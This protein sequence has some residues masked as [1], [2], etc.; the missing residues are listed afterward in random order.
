MC[1]FKKLILPIVVGFMCMSFSLQAQDILCD[2]SFV[3]LAGQ[4]IPVGTVNLIFDNG[5]L[6]VVIDIT[7]P[8]W[9]L[10]ITHVDAGD[11]RNTF[12]VNQNDLP[13]VGKF[14]ST[15][16]GNKIETM[17][18]HILSNIETNTDGTIVVAVHAEVF[19]KDAITGAILQEESAWAAGTF[20][21]ETKNW[22]QFITCTVPPPPPP[23]NIC[24][25]LCKETI[26]VGVAVSQITINP[27][28]VTQSGSCDT[29]LSNAI[30]FQSAVVSSRDDRQLVIQAAETA[31][32]R[33]TCTARFNVQLGQGEA[34][35]PLP[36]LTNISPTVITQQ[37]ADDCLSY[38][39]QQVN[40]AFDAG[41][42]CTP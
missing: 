4:S 3:L 20:F 7:E 41:I 35:Y 12:P 11:Q 42:V 18:T 14:T 31:T 37:E 22:S 5:D 34:I 23:T 38:L 26:D 16:D 13:K 6:Q 24:P 33:F 25:Q 39:V 1:F 28:V 40:T 8:G 15:V 21:N 29:G 10:G 2:Q 36:L 30:F 9:F 19:K 17:V 32:G 27:D